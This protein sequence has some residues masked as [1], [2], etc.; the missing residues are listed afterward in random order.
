MIIFKTIVFSLL[1]YTRKSQRFSLSYRN[2]LS[3]RHLI[4]VCKNRVKVYIINLY[5]TLPHHATTWMSERLL[6]RDW[7]SIEKGWDSILF[8]QRF[9]HL[10]MKKIEAFLSSPK[11][12]ETN[13]ISTLRTKISL[14]KKYDSWCSFI[15]L[16]FSSAASIRLYDSRFQSA[17]PLSIQFQWS[18][19][20]S[21]WIQLF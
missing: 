11:S 16:S 7:H 19:N 8:W 12:T 1:E 2:K 13:K 9:N 17:A 18:M 3:S 15:A 20:A 21:T 14:F 6:L 5:S 10:N 4:F